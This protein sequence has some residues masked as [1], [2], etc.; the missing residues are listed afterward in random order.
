D[1]KE[2]RTGAERSANPSPDI[3][4]PGASAAN[5]LETVEIEKDS[6]DRLVRIRL[7]VDC[8]ITERF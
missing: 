5:A 3:L 8:Q 4:S 1:D 2:R 7:E 6:F